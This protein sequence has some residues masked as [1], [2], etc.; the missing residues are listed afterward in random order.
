MHELL[1]DLPFLACRFFEKTFA[2]V[3]NICIFAT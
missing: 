3:I 1:S 2:Y